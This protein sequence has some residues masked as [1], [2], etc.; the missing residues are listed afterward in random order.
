RSRELVS[1]I[2]RR[3]RYYTN[4]SDANMLYGRYAR[5][6]EIAEIGMERAQEKGFARTSGSMLAGN[7][8]E[9]LIALGEWRR[10]DELLTWASKLMPPIN[11]Q[12]YQARLRV[13]LLLWRGHLDDAAEEL[14]GFRRLAAG[15]HI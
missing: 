4:A 11:H 1:E 12:L 15:R 2:S 6:V 9:P 5:A 3:M 10:A 8:V 14:A 13:W 7:A